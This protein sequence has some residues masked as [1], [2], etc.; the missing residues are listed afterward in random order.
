MATPTDLPEMDADSLTT[1]PREEGDG[2]GAGAV[3]LPRLSGLEMLRWAWR[4]LT[5]MR[6]ALILLFLLSLA[7]IPGSL[8]PQR[9]ANTDPTLVTAWIVKHKTLGPLLDHLQ[10]FTVYKSAWF[11]AIYLLL[12]VSLIG[13][14]LPRTAQH[15]RVLRKPP[16]AAPRN[17]ARMPAHFRWTDTTGTSIE[18]KLGA[19][20]LALKKKRF[21]VVRGTDADGGGWVSGEKGYLREAGN[22]VFH[23]SLVGI[24]AGFAI[25]GYYGYQGKVLVTEGGGFTNISMNYDDHTFGGGVDPDKLPPFGLTLNKFTAT[26][27]PNRNAPDYGQ[28]RDFTADVSY[29]S[30][31]S[32]PQKKATLKENRPLTVDGVNVYLS[33]H[34]YSPVI[35]IRDKAGNAIVDHKPVEFF[36]SGAMGVG[37]GIYK[38]KNGYVDKFG[39]PQP[40]GISGIFVP[41]YPGEMLPGLGA[42]SLFP[43]ASNPALVLSA[44]TG[45]L[46]PNPGVYT[47]DVSKAQRVKL[48]NPV[49]PTNPAVVLTLQPGKNTVA[50]PDGTGTIEFDGVRQW[51]QFDLNH[52]PSKTLVFVSAVGIVAGLIGSLGIRRRRVFVRVKPAERDALRVEVAG[53]ARAEDARLRDEVRGVGRGL[54]PPKAGVQK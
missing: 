20:E 51:A 31:P 6:V 49:D 16:P 13:C 37:S 47:M 2:T 39:S 21:R 50:L 10:F 7:A 8:L 46:G 42:V 28:A 9:S 33:S 36:D 11:S 12:F 48:P 23:L 45:D 17:L 30:S 35:T 54:R 34:G 1:A 25:K 41:D 26:Y 24:L 52:D 43:V 19:A 44:Y 15:L 14:I 29:N 53:L 32:S 4:Q 18:D 40:L 38:V 5:S 3:T 27:E 22:L